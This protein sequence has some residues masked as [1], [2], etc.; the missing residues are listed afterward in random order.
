MENWT[1]RKV[2]TNGHHDC[3]RYKPRRW[4]LPKTIGAIIVGA[5]SWQERERRFTIG[6]FDRGRPADPSRPM[7]KK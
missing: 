5:F 6:F 3:R 4:S 1:R 7:E 2:M